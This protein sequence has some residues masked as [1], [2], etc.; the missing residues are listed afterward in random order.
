MT[1]R[2]GKYFI[3][4][5]N[6]RLTPWIFFSLVLLSGLGITTTLWRHA[7]QQRIERLRLAF[8]S[9]SDM[10]TQVIRSRINNYSVV[11]RGV[12]GFFEGSDYISIEE[13]RSYIQALNVQAKLPGVQGIG[14]VTLVPHSDKSRHIAEIR[15]QNIPDYSIK[16]E[17]QR[18]VYAPISHIEPLTDDN[19]KALGFDTF[20]LPHART[21]MELSRDTGEIAITPR[22]TLV[23]DAGK[24]DVFAFVMYL[25]I[26]KQGVKL[27]TPAEL[28]AANAGWVDVPFRM[29]DFMAGLRGEIDPDLDFDI[30]DRSPDYDPIP[31][32]HSDA[33][34]HHA[35]ALSGSLQTSR[36]LEFGGR[37]W[38]LQLSTTPAFKDRISSGDHA[39]LI[40]TAG[41]AVTLTLSL[42]TWLLSSGRESAHSRFRLLFKQAGDGILLISRDHRLIDANPA[43]LKMLG[44]S[45][46][47]L[48]E[49]RLPDI[50]ATHEHSRLEFDVN[51]MMPGITHLEEWIHVRKDGSE[52]AAE[53][54]ASQLN[55]QFYLTILRDLT[56]RKNAE[57]RILRLT[58]LYQALSETN[59]A[60]VRMIDES[61]L[62][63]LVCRCAVDFGGMKMAWIGQLNKS[64]QRIEP[65]ARYG[66]GL[67]F[68]D[69]LDYSSRGDLQLDCGITGK[70]LLEN[71]PV[72]VK[73][74]LNDPMTRHWHESAKTFG[75]HSAAAFPIQRNDKPFA[76]F[77]VYHAQKD[78]FD[79]DAINL[80]K[81]MADDISFALDNFDRENQRQLT[82]K[83]LY[84]SESHFRF[85]TE[86][87]QALI[88]VSD[89]DKKC[90]WFNKVWLDFTGR[91][92]EQEL[93][94]GWME[95]V[96]P[97]DIHQCKDL[98]FSQFDHQKPF[99][100]EYRLKHHDGQYRWIF[101][102]GAPYFDDQGVFQ[103]YIGSCQDVT[104]R[105]AAEQALAENEAKM[106]AV[107]E[108]V[109]ACIYIKDEAGRYQFV[110]RNCLTLW[111]LTMDEVIGATDEK[112]FDEQSAA[113]IRKN[114]R[115]VLV[116]G[117][118]VQT[119]ESNIVTSTGK[120]ASYWAVKI[121]LRRENGSIYGLCG[122]STDISELKRLEMSLR[123]NEKLLSESQRI[124]QIGSWR[125]DL[126]ANN[127]TWSDE[128]YHIFQ[129]THD[130][131]EQNLE[132]FTK[133][134]HPQERP[135]L[136][137]WLNGILE[138]ETAGPHQ[139]KLLLPEGN[140]RILEMHGELNCD[141]KGKPIAING[142]VQDITERLQAEQ[143]LRLNAQVFDFSREGII[144]TD[145]QNKI[146]SVNPAYTEISG[147]S[148]QESL[149]KNPRLVS[150]GKQDKAFYEDMWRQ[151]LNQGHW[152]GE[153]INRRK[154]GSLYPQ[155]LSI[156][157]I[158]DPSGRISHHIGILNDLSEHKAAEERIQFL[159]NFDPL[160]HLPNRD[161]LRDRT[162]LA[163][164]AAQRANSSFALMYLDVDR[165]KI[166]N[167]SM[168]PSIGDQLLK[169]LANRFI[170]HL[171]PDD[172]V[173]RQGGDE[174]IFLLP[175][176]DAEGAA[177]VAQKML[178]L[179][180]QPFT[181]EG[182][183]MT[184]TASIGIAQYPQDGNELEQLA[185]SA[186]AALFRAKQNGRNNFQFF[187]RQLHQHAHEMLQVENELRQALERN[188][189]ILYYQPQIDAKTS[190][191][192]GVEALIRWQHP[193]KGMV[194][195]G[196]F[197]PI[198]EESG[199]IVDI[200]DWVL[201]TAI[202]QNVTWQSEGLDIVP[203][204][205]N[206]SVAQFRQ[207]R[208]YRLIAQSLREYKLDPALLELEMTEG[209]AMENTEQTISTLNQ[210][211]ALGV[212]LAIDD[213]GTGYSSLSYLKRFQIDKLKIDQ[214]FVRDLGRDTEDAAIVTAII[215]MAKGLGF[216]TIAEGVETQ[217]QLDF[218][219]EKQC[220]EIQ[221]YFF[222]KPVPPEVFAEM[223]RKGSI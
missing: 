62:F 57:Q 76:V 103:G 108:N 218:L 75:W 33:V 73:D 180:A 166:V 64:D 55:S 127:V 173:C 51:L 56:E 8:E 99:S 50:V 188:E 4:E 221:G 106:S 142:T 202:R 11:M 169:E 49:R 16:P 102:N 131:F 104:E 125:I 116:E 113:Q 123:D 1:H 199:L 150:S 25:P 203:V 26:Y 94:N 58:H 193:Q 110:N 89:T 149:G 206:L 17:G 141:A 79:K 137:K 45:R 175:N 69:N 170:E 19:L 140:E 118:A 124:A 128:T 68:L 48:L 42:L 96:H 146:V 6:R 182:Q 122:I 158:R 174:F 198:A 112:L 209:I 212:K 151:I 65:V 159:S 87:S 200:G 74:Y 43:A 84:K 22:I 210:L 20:T 132:A 201:H 139:F 21:T 152:Q 216:K 111:N 213:F 168:G 88:W 32:Y 120:A 121:P 78:A 18:A 178:E 162:Q 119:E 215:G 155:W 220:D 82:E 153:V 214:S 98:F 92:M 183:R 34:S 28:R 194:P 211:H 222:S 46:N 70:A 3:G 80:L 35:R 85:V 160:T 39:L 207:D 72:I 189:L 24:Q 187:T 14:L 171:H 181:L 154:N 15:K 223:L 208:L 204:A 184:L 91:T 101:D 177:H 63:P 107:L 47:E 97:D 9:S 53:V 144:I 157:V 60:I 205:V 93:G 161:L 71:R 196:R 81:E 37:K 148:F 176:T 77:S 190:K 130:N 185:Q 41:I 172:T 143:Q 54:C 156:S 61:E 59:Q 30:H 29:N 13:F 95:G 12:K 117:K 126:P 136:Q 179:I 134:I 186:D 129:T 192:I 135:G 86:S 36:E 191:I 27:N 133:R 67:A 2:S 31:L 44:Y 66:E 38:I 52:F 5:V 163:L 195:P 114:D 83:A 217:D 90:T 10:A 145:A 197:I 40:A 105:K 219:R 138:H 115:C 7:E 167:D 109:S 100:M 164:A 23:Q 147:Y 165:F